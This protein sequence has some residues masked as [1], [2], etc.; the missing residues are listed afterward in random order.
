MITDELLRQAAQEAAMRYVDNLPDVGRGYHN[1]SKGFQRKIKKLIAKSRHPM[2]YRNRKRIAGIILFILLGSS[3]VMLPNEK[4]QAALKQWIESIMNGYTSYRYEGDLESVENGASYSL[5][6]VPDGTM[7][8][9]RI[10]SDNYV[11]HMYVD[12][13]GHILCFAYYLG[14]NAGELFLDTQGYRCE[15][16]EIDGKMAEIY[17][18][19][20]SQKSN[21]IVWNDGVVLFQISG[22]LDRDALIQMVKKI[23]KN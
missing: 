9:E 4:I 3:L 21:G 1:Y 12:A 10:E 7:F 18:S 16:E 20:D 6:W 15:M 23:E 19:S 5:G 11:Y 8:L 22:F 17:I 13:N 2:I 14:N